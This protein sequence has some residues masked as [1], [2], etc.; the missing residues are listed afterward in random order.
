[1]SDHATAYS[2]ATILI[3]APA[4][5]LA[6]FLYHPHIGNPTDADFLARLAGAVVADPLRWAVSHL[7]VAVGCGLIVLAFLALRGRL[8]EEGEDRWSGP[9]LPFIVMGSVLY[10]LL[11]AMELGPLAVART[12]AD[13]EAIAAT[14]AALFTWF[15]PVLM[16]SA[17]LFLIGATGFAM[18]ILRGAI[19]SS[20]GAR[21]VALSLVAMA[22]SRLVPLSMVQFHIQ[23]TL[24][25]VA[26]WPAAYA[27]VKPPRSRSVATSR[28]E[29]SAPAVPR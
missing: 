25:V 23:G 6:A 28:A 29:A 12:G 21:L 16:T 1:M 19:L 2:R 11:P 24:G 7:M 17:V 10:A 18:G 4:V 22:V 15:V 27:M 5:M 13:T 20:P 9:A 8:R 26:L 3:I 14:Q